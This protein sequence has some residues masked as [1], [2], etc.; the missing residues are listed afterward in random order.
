MAKSK[1]VVLV[2]V[3]APQRGRVKTRLAAGTGPDAALRIYRRLGEHTISEALQLPN[4]EVRVHFTPADA[5]QAVRSWLGEGPL[6]LPQAEGDLGRR[7]AH[8]FAAAWTAGADR[9]LVIGSDLPDVSA[10][11]IQRAFAKLAAA[12]AVLGPAR[13][14]GYYLLAL[15]RPISGVFDGVDWS[16]ERVLRQT[17]ERLRAANVEP[18]LLEPLADVDEVEDLPAGWAAWAARPS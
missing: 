17:V 18:A 7:L 13:D 6:Y 2:F 5:E 1:R 3:R 12:D 9:V 8:A 10:E 16:T 14:G 15:R 11:R 4:T